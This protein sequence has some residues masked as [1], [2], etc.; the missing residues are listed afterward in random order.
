M[1]DTRLKQIWAGFEA[2]TT[3]RLVNR[4]VDHIAVPHRRDL[5][6]EDLSLLQEGFREPSAAGFAALKTRLTERKA[7]PEKRG[8]R[9]AKADSDTALPETAQFAPE[10]DAARD[11]I[12]ALRATDFR[13]RRPQFDYVDQVV[14]TKKK[15][16]F[17]GGKAKAGTPKAKTEKKGFKL[18]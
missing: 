13:T 2:A 14:V 8:G 3:R 7:K 5:G 10:T 18:F 11:L 12:K 16:L 9:S 1:T 17:S 6:A 4:A 15:G